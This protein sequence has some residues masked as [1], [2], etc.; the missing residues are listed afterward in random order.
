MYVPNKK[1]THIFGNVECP[2]LRIK[3]NTAQCC[4]WLATHME[5]KQTEL[6]TENK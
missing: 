4:Q 3:T 2:I 5:E 1:G 6:E